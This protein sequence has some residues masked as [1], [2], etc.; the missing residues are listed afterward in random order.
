MNK[1]LF[2]INPEGDRMACFAMLNGKIVSI[3]KDGVPIRDAYCVT[4]GPMLQF[5]NDAVYQDGDG[6]NDAVTS[7]I[8]PFYQAC[9]NETS[10]APWTECGLPIPI[11]SQYGKHVHVSE[12]ETFASYMEYD[13]DVAITLIF[14][15]IPKRTYYWRVI[16]EEG[17][18]V[19]SGS[20]TTTGNIRQIRIS[21]INNVRDPGGI[22]CDGGMIAYNKIWRGNRADY[23]TAKGIAEFKRW[24]ITGHL[25]LR[26][27]NKQY[28]GSILGLNYYGTVYNSN[29]RIT[30][31]KYGINSYADLLITPGNFLNCIEAILTE[32]EAGGAV[33]FNCKYGSDRTGSMAALLMGL[34]GCS[35]DSIIKFWEMTSVCGLL[36]TKRIHKQDYTNF[37]KGEMRDMLKYLYNNYGG[38]SGT[39]VPEQIQLWFRTKVCKGLS[40]LGAGYIERLRRCLVIPAA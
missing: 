37:P 35:E 38:S 33:F 25:D 24:G 19:R 28:T 31:D 10:R 11:I 21:G 15:L 40:D 5:W 4:N 26:S 22:P 17:D 6:I 20:F 3:S 27:A 39:T 18:L 16:D 12:D 2:N 34:L 29:K 23:V 1:F 8:D 9:T 36:N 13:A 14:N 30:A 32:L 7:K